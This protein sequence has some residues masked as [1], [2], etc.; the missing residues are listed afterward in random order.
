MIKM[1]HKDTEIFNC[2]IKTETV[3]QTKDTISALGPVRFGEAHYIRFEEQTNHYLM[4]T[5]PN[6]AK[7]L[8]IT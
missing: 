6:H 7:I 5:L 8:G 1:V 3:H 4:E 2:T